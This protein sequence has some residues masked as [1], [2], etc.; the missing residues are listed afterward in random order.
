MHHACVVVRDIE[1]A[2][3]EG[4]NLGIGPWKL[5]NIEHPGTKEARLHGKE[6]EF[7]AKLALADSKDGTLEF[8][9][10]ISGSSAYQEYLDKHGE[11]IHHIAYYIPENLD[12]EVKELTGKGIKV[13][14]STT[15]RGCTYYYFET[16]DK[17]GVFLELFTGDLGE[18]AKI[19]KR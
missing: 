12:K 6:V 17:I 16:V 2:I 9:Q 15:Y 3:K 1:K 19:Y 14:Q 13:L 8:I 5:W 10:P 4:S 11:G 18:P 7:S